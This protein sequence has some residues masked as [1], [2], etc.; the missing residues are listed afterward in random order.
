M[1][2]KSGDSF[3]SNRFTFVLAAVGSAVG[4]GNI[5]RYPATVF[6]NGGGAFFIPYFIAF[7]TAG[8]PILILEFTVGS[9]W[10][11]AGPLAYARINKKWEF[12][13][14]M[15]T[16]VA[17]MIVFFYVV[18]LAWAVNFL[19]FSIQGMAWG[20]DP[21]GF[22][23]GEFLG[24]TG[25]PIVLGAI[26]W[27]VVASLVVL[28]GGTW[29][30]SSR[31]LKSGLERFNVILLPLMFIFMVGLM[32][33]ATTL[34]G[35]TAG[36][37]ALFTPD[38]AVLATPGVWIAAYGQIF[39]SLS[40]CMGI[41]ITYG[42]Y[43]KKNS[44]ITNTAMT[45]GFADIGIAMVA[46]TAVFSILG[47]MATQQ[48]VAVDDV[49]TGGAGL[50]FTVFPV[51]FNLMGAVGPWFATFFFL[52]LLIAGMTSFVSLIEA[53]SQPFVEKFN[54]ERKKM[55][56]ITCIIGFFA[57]LLYATGA[58]VHLLTIVNYVIDYFLTIGGFLQVICVI[59][60]FKKAPEIQAFVN[61]NAYIKITN[62]WLIPIKY[63]FPVVVAAI[64]AT[65]VVDFIGGGAAAHS[66]EVLIIVHGGTA[67]TMILGMA[68]L[69][70]IKWRRNIEDYEK[71]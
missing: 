67:L 40:V 15:G 38:F 34:P 20:P 64:T 57:S 52:V 53:F 35:A 66:T 63:I 55:F 37:N 3:W 68:I 10:R 12:L 30:V 61:K 39:F 59:W 29:L 7:F 13:G 33:W 17:G 58:G 6:D 41:M 28:W 47:Y 44:E 49:A 36:L 71:E 27:P 42:S 60:L 69:P 56:T 50:V 51:A 9:K 70:R 46:A 31:D 24:A 5:W 43:L 23:F 16:M 11:G 25:N 2:Q 18:I 26:N 19:I 65:W 22:F 1:Q 8:L 54:V 32:I 14:W 62:W 4:L 21:G 48:G 45:I